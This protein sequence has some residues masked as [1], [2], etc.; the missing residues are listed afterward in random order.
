MFA[1][2]ADIFMILVVGVTTGITVSLHD[3]RIR[4]SFLMT[5]VTIA[6]YI[7]DTNKVQIQQIF[8]SIASFFDAITRYFT[9]QLKSNDAECKGTYLSLPMKYLG[10]DYNLLVSY[11]SSLAREMPTYYTLSNGKKKAFYHPPGVPLLIT[12]KDIGVDELVREI[13]EEVSF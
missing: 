9:G 12:A 11:D 10:K 2:A 4:K 7:T 13:E 6:N 3:E 1:L 5:V 8:L